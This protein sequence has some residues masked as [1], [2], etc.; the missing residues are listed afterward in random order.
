MIFLYFY[1]FDRSDFNNRLMLI[2]GS[3][4]KA[5]MNTTAVIQEKAVN[6]LKLLFHLPSLS[7]SLIMS[8]TCSSEG[9]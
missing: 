6:G 9:F 8:C 4:I 1:N 5:L 3:P 7:T 2:T